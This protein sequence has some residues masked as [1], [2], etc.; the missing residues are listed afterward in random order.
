MM[1]FLV[2]C[3]GSLG[4]VMSY[5]GRLTDAAGQPLSGNYAFTFR[6]YNASTGGTSVYTETQTIAVANGLFDTSV[7]PT[8]ILASMRPEDLA[9][10]LWLDVTI[11]TETLTPRQRLF[12]LSLCLHPHAG[13]GDFIDIQCHHSG[14]HGG[15]HC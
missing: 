10:P 11:G 7:G 13:G 15:C 6:L 14:H 4:P 9:Q 1:A 3:T 2:G 5:Q 12:G 8:T